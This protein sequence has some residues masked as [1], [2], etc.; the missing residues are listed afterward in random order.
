MARILLLSAEASLF[1]L[2]VSNGHTIVRDTK[3]HHDLVIADEPIPRSP[4]PVIVFTAIGNV[5]ARIRALDLGADDA[6]DAGFALSQMVARVGAVARRAAPDSIEAD[7]CTIDL[8]ALTVTRGNQVSELTP[9][10]A[11]VIRW[12]H[13][14]R[15]RVVSR[16]ELLAH[17]W[18]VSPNN[19]TRAV[20]M[21]IS[22]LRAK[23]EAEPETPTI[24][25]SVKGA[26]Y[27]WSA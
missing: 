26:G 16:S 18:G 12:L 24:L 20:D 23:I 22:G 19:T 6:F 21:A 14:H 8:L 3:L 13:R 25:R 15:P 9:R 27:R 5:E 2:L 17:V 1:A 11:E 7:G 10:E 4:R